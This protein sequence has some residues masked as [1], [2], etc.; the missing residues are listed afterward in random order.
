[1]GPRFASVD[2][3]YERSIAVEVYHQALPGHTEINE[4]HPLVGHGLRTEKVVLGFKEGTHFGHFAGIEVDERDRIAEPGRI[5]LV[6]ES[7]ITGHVLPA[8]RHHS[9]VGQGVQPAVG[10]NLAVGSQLHHLDV[11]HGLPGLNGHRRTP[12]R[13]RIVVGHGDGQRP[14]VGTLR[15]HPRSLRLHR[16]LGRRCLHFDGQRFVS[17]AMEGT[18]HLAEIHELTLLFH[19]RGTGRK[20]RCKYRQDKKQSSLHTFVLFRVN[21]LELT[22]PI[23]TPAGHMT[24]CSNTNL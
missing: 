15:R 12:L 14:A 13:R 17:C 22:P 19:F 11:L 8:G 21:D 1:M 18:H 5:A 20:S 10:S 2:A 4:Q 23:V 7:R 24:F 16:P 3:L 9:P 6:D